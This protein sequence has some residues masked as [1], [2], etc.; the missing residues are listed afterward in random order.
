MTKKRR[1]LLPISQVLPESPVAE[2]Y[3][4]IRTNIQFGGFNPHTKLLLVTST[5]AG[6]GK[7]STS[8]NLAIVS[9]QAG[10]RVLVMDADF[11]NPQIHA[12]LDMAPTGQ[13]LCSVL[14][15]E[16]D[17]DSC[18]Y[19]CEVPSLTVL[20][21]GQTAASP[22][23]L[24]SGKR[25][26]Q[27]LQH[28]RHTFDLVIIDSPPVLTVS[29][30]LIMAPLV[31]GVVFV[32]DAQKTNRM[33]AQRAIAAITQVKGTVVGAVLNRIPKNEQRYYANIGVGQASYPS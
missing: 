13:G 8:I 9:A 6:E 16:A 11:R 7:T 15:G 2:S 10:R 22:A 26:Q 19:P 24:L 31:D 27:T 5:H 25:F 14:S 4:T 29:D 20:P 17:P 3:H 33:S 12:R 30:S 1:M 23:V 28:F 18:L 32:V 21:S